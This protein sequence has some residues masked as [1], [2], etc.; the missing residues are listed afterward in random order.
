LLASIAM[1]EALTLLS[2][3]YDDADL[4]RKFQE[5]HGWIANWG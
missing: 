5:S 2:V 1:L 4:G 3:A